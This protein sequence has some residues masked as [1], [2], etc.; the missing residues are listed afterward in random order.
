VYGYGECY[1]G[2]LSKKQE[3]SVCKYIPYLGLSFLY[4]EMTAALTREVDT[5]HKCFNDIIR[6]RV[7]SV[8]KSD[9]PE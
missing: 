4:D 7:D 6:Y 3:R 5:L 8:Y 1:S 9:H 2:G